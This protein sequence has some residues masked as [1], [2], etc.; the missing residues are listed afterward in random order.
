MNTIQDHQDAS[1]QGRID[2]WIWGWNFALAHPITG[3]GFHSYLLHQTGTWEH[4]AY[5]EAH[6]IFFE[7]MADHGFVGLGLMLMLFLGMIL[8]CQGIT[9]RAR[10]IP[11][12]EWAANLGAMLQ[13][14]M[15][16]FITGSQFLH[17]ATQSMPYELCALSL[18]VRGILERR[19]AADKAAA[20][21]AT[22]GLGVRRPAAAPAPFIPANAAWQNAAKPPF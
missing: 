21:S 2:S 7:T 1:S 13:L 3:G 15:W 18:A 19:I 10:K 5:L 22:A 17:S 11:G 12:M 6:N 4:P 20:P 9:K 14:A 8:N 16:T